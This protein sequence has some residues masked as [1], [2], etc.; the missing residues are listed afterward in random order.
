[1]LRRP[2]LGLLA[3]FALLVDSCLIVVAVLMG[4]LILH[5]PHRRLIGT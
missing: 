4:L 5:G 3:L 2:I 1:V